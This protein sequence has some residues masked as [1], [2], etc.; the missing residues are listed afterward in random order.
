MYDHPEAYFY[1]KYYILFYIFKY[2][3]P[4]KYTRIVK[5]PN[6]KRIQKYFLHSITINILW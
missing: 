3:Y 2:K 1:N 4:L 6:A 5:L